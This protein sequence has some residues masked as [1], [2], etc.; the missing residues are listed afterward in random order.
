MA[1]RYTAAELIQAAKETGGNK[2]AAGRRLGCSRQ[3][4]E[5]YCKRYTTVNEAFENE[6]RAMVDWAESHLRK[7]VIAGAEW[8]VKFVLRTLGKDRGYTERTEHSIGGTG[9][10][11]VV[12][13]RWPEDG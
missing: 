1:R 3:T 9:E 4:V 5:N 12:H 13:L 2:S 7:Y 10:P 11:L 6:R 8:A